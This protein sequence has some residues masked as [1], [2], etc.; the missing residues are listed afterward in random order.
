MKTTDL[1]ELKGNIKTA[2]QSWS[3]SKIEG[4]FPGKP[5]TKVVLKNGLNN[6]MQRYDEKLNKMIDG[7]IMFVGK[8]GVVD[9]DIAL[10]LLI[11][12]FEEMDIQEYQF[13]LIPISVGKGEIIAKLPSNPILD[14]IVGNLGLLKITSEDIFEIKEILNL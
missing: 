4:L 9:T 10:D 11:G 7:G 1:N 14:A 8:D 2:L 3:D 13:G 6:L 5:K 12:I